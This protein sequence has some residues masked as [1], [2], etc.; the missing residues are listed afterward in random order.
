[1]LIKAKLPVLR[2]APPWVV[3]C[4]ALRENPFG[5]YLV[6]AGGVGALPFYILLILNASSR[7]TGIYQRDKDI[8]KA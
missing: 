8:I 7:A 3:V 6:R 1:V 2:G 4:G 5:D